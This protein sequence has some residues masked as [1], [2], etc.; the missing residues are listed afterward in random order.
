MAPS[1][2]DVGI[3]L[4]NLVVPGGGMILVGR[5]WTGL[6]VGMLFAVTANYAI[7]A[8]LLF[9][10]DAP[11]WLQGLAI[12]LCGGSYLGAQLRMG[13]CL[14]EARQQAVAEVRDATLRAVSACLANNQADE[15]LAAMEP[16]ADMA[17]RDLLVAYRFAQVLTKTGDA[18]AARRAWERVRRL[19]RHRLY[20]EICD[21]RLR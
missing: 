12:G 10:D 6:A 7:I 16:I 18:S 19:D 3:K 17:E 1:A 4:F 13:S 2:R 14:R 5:L 15:A 8:T 9:P 11:G 20:R 21:E